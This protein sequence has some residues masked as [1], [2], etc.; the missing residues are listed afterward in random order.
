M[1]S[2]A[3]AAPWSDARR[4]LQD[5]EGALHLLEIA[6]LVDPDP[7]RADLREAQGK[8]EKDSY[9]L[10]NRDRLLD[11]GIDFSRFTTTRNAADAIDLMRAMGFRQ[12][13]VYGVSYGTR[14]ALEM[15]RAA[16]Q[17]LRAVVLDSP[18]PPQVNAELS[19]AWLLQRSFELFSRICELAGAD[20]VKTATGFGPGGATADHDDVVAM[21]HC[22]V[23]CRFIDCGYFSCGA[24]APGMVPRSRGSRGLLGIADAAQYTTGVCRRAGIVQW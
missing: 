4:A 12:W 15:M 3:W 22:C 21:R 14:V 7:L 8:L 16:P 19:D 11:E 1:S 6:H 10:R 2:R 18:Y 20:F 23:S 17:H 13:D 24:V 5:D 9:L